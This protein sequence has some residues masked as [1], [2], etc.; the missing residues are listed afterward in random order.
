MWESFFTICYFL[1]YWWFYICWSL[2]EN[3]YFFISLRCH[4]TVKIFTELFFVF[5]KCNFKIVFAKILFNCKLSFIHMSNQMI[6]ISIVYIL[7]NC[8]NSNLY[9][10][11]FHTWNFSLKCHLEQ[12]KIGRKGLKENTHTRFIKASHV[13]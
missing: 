5:T 12:K 3:C 8:F 1:L 2:F 7:E 10:M 11:S 6:V 4:R 13:S 9:S